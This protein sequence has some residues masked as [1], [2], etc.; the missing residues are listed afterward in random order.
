MGASMGSDR[1]LVIEWSTIN[2]DV[3]QESVF[4]VMLLA[5]VNNNSPRPRWKTR[6]MFTVD[7]VLDLSITPFVYA[8]SFFDEH[9]RA[10][11]SNDNVLM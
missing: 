10:I 3:S 8:E 4:S 7:H 1:A 5:T 6:V 11:T 2:G 9:S